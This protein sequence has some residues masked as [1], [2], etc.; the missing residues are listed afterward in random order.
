MC[1]LLAVLMYNTD[2]RKLQKT[3][4]QTPEPSNYIEK[5]QNDFSFFC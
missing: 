1:D 4:M 2:G 3:H 5:Y